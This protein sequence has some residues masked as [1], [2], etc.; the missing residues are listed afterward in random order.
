MQVL[1]KLLERHPEKLPLSFGEEEIHKVLDKD[2]KPEPPKSKRR[3]IHIRDLV[4]A[5]GEYLMTIMEAMAVIG[6]SRG[7]LDSRRDDGLLTDVKLG[8][9]GRAIRHIS[10]EVL[11]LS[12]VYSLRK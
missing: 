4:L 11:H 1:V 12:K 9:K 8:D 3:V 5:E 2:E 7:T 10:T 6:I